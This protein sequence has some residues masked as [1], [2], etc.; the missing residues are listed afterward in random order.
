M[1]SEP[2]R[3]PHELGDR[4][5]SL[6][7][8]TRFQMRHL[9]E[10]FLQSTMTLPSYR[11]GLIEP[12]RLEADAYRIFDVL[13]QALATENELPPSVVAAAQKIGEER[14]AI[15]VAL[16][17]L[18]T[19]L[20]SDF[21]IL[22]D[23]ITAQLEESDQH[24]TIHLAPYL[25]RTIE[26]FVEQVERGFDRTTDD[27]L[28]RWFA[29]ERQLLPLLFNGAEIGDDWLQIIA[30]GM[31]SSV[32]DFFL[33]CAS[34]I[35]F[36]ETIDNLQL[37]L[38]TRGR[39]SLSH[40]TGTH[41]L[42]LVPAIPRN[43]E[44]LSGFQSLS[45]GVSEPIR[46]LENVARAARLAIDVNT[47]RFSFESGQLRY[48]DVWERITAKSHRVMAP[49]FFHEIDSRLAAIGLAEQ[50]TLKETIIAVSES[51]TI[52]EAASRLFCHRNTIQNRL[53]RV[54]KVTG[55]DVG[56]PKWLFL[57]YMYALGERPVARPAPGEKA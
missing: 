35:D 12:S 52:A 44:I 43:L 25:L 57:L 6:I 7:A 18:R 15:G 40:W 11:T 2:R 4:W 54:T 31:K 36:Q 56:T 51:P 48:R 8:V 46:R 13:L 30:R 16:P 1:H 39:P 37:E 21:F 53:S 50:Q 47:H 27:R 34:S 23:N 17:D 10:R 32:D 28:A 20:R 45:I 5:E 42:V 38:R 24:M 33:V 19:A 55:M 14:G 29:R 9:V 26:A 3:L 49:E 41:L 22:W